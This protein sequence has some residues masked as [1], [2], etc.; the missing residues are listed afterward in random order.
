VLA[1]QSR[2]ADR[3]MRLGT[4]GSVDT[5]LDALREHKE[6]KHGGSSPPPVAIDISLDVFQ[7]IESGPNARVTACV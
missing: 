1:C 2:G 7:G 6:T 5:I 3:K 4:A